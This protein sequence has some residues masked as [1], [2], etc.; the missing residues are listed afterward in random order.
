MTRIKI[1]GK[2]VHASPD[3]TVLR[4]AE[5]AGITIP[6]LCDHP[7]LSMYGGCRLC[8]VEVQGYRQPVTACTLPVSEGLVIKTK[9]PAL[10]QAR[11]AILKMLLRSYTDP[12]YDPASPPQTS[13]IHWAREYGLDPGEV[14]GKQ[15]RSQPLLCTSI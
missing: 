10:Y 12:E 7:D 6:T 1:N 13:F 8:V 15:Q 11:Q 9:T 3:S 14:M 5:A 4:A 2:I